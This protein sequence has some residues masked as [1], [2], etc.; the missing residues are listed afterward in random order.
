M[1]AT[2]VIWCWICNECVLVC[3][4]DDCVSQL[5]MFSCWHLWHI[6]SSHLGRGLSDEF[7]D[8][9]AIFCHWEDEATSNSQAE[10]DSYNQKMLKEVGEQ[11]VLG[12]KHHRSHGFSWLLTIRKL[13]FWVE[14][15]IF[16]Y[17]NLLQFG[18][19]LYHGIPQMIQIWTYFRSWTYNF[20]DP[21]WLKKLPYILSQV[22]SFNLVVVFFSYII[23]IAFCRF[24][25]G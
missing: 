2:T 19:F 1:N 10:F 7:C 14:Y 20:G 22:V 6:F 4:V 16:R 21:P 24:Y 13:L 3:L 11:L 17:A 12:Q 8:T 15:A 23:H 18:G 5:E 25:C 9:F